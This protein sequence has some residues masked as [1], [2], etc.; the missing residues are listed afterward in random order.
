MTT[1][2]VAT[3][4]MR[5]KSVYHAREWCPRIGVRYD[6]TQGCYVTSCDPVDEQEA[7]AAGL[8]PC[9]LCTAWREEEGR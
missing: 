6:R 2:Y 8:R 4:A 9:P 3:T 5:R 7:I 1:V